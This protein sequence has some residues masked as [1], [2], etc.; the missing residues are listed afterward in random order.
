MELLSEGICADSVECLR[1]WVV[2]DVLRDSQSYLKV[3]WYYL[4]YIRLV[5][6]QSVRYPENILFG[7]SIHTSFSVQVD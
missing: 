2:I 6:C 4:I 1:P 7:Q 5:M 3:V